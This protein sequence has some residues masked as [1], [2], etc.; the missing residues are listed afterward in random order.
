FLAVA[1][2]HSDAK[3]GA[4]PLIRGLAIRTMGCIRV[5]EI[6]SYLCE[7]LSYC[8]KDKDA[9][10]RKTAAMCVSKLYQ[11][12]PQ[13]VREN[14]FINTLHECLDDE[15]PIVVANA[16]S[17]LS[18]ISIL[19]GV[20]QIKI[21]SKN[22][23]NIIDA[24]SKANEWAQVQILDALVFYNTKKSSHAEEV[25]EGVMP[26]LSHVNQSVVM[27]TIKVIMKFMDCIDD[28]E[29][30]KTY[31][32]KLTNSI[33]SVLISYPEIQYILLRSLHA[34]VLKRP[35]LLEKEFKYFYVQYNDPIYIKLEKVDILY[36]LCNKKNYEM[37]IQEFT[38]YALTETNPELIQKS[39]RYIGYVGYK[40]ESSYDLCVNSISK[41]IDNNNE[42]A[43]PECI[44]VSRDLMRKYKN[45]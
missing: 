35:I 25:I 6:V 39:I 9:Y 32:K 20:N 21:K 17:A 16:M 11:T 45:T 27:S 8:I 15:N 42:D 44:I 24:L 37:I 41:I 30:I 22:L 10:V 4:T 1:A 18:E 14:G 26:R 29:K 33:M 31:C 12:S 43:V 5:P 7:T 19:S 13:Q 36:K 28:I 23:K 38:S 40:F 2:F 3:E 34:I